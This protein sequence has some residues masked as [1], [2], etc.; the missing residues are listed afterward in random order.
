MDFFERQDVARR[1][2]ALL[3]FYFLMA[4]ILIIA[5]VYAVFAFTFLVLADDEEPGRTQSSEIAVQ[6]FWDP[7]LFTGV[8][9]GTIVLVSGGSLYRI[10][11]LSGG[12]HTVAE[13]LGGRLLHPDTSDPDERKLLNVV[14][15]MAIASGVPVPPVY[16]MEKESGINAFAAGFQPG[17]AVIGVTR[18]CI[19][20]LNRDELQGV[21]A[22][23][24][25]HILNGDMRLNVRLMGVLFGILLISIVG[26]IIFRST[27]VSS[28]RSYSNDN[29]KGG[30]PLP[31]LGLALYA[32]GYIGVIFGRLIK[33]AI[34]RQRE[35]LADASAVQFT[36]NPDGIANALKKIGALSEGSKLQ[37]PEA[38]EASHMFFGDAI[39]A[40][41]LGLMAT[42]P[43][44]TARIRQ[45][46]PTFDGDFSKVRREL[47]KP[48]SERHRETLKRAT[49]SERP[50]AGSKRLAFDP[51]KAI[52]EIGTL[53]PQRLAYAAALLDAMPEPVTRMAHEPHGARAL[54]Y[55]LLLDNDEEVRKVQLGQLAEG[56]DPQVDFET[57]KILPQVRQLDP[58]ARLPMV[59]LAL[60]A[61]HQLSP[62]QYQAFRDNIRKLIEADR[63][64]SL[65]EFA[66]RQMLMRHL[67]PQ[68]GELPKRANRHRTIPPLVEP[69]AKVLS[70]LARVGQRDP[71][72]IEQAFRAGVDRLNWS[73]QR[74][75]LCPPDRCGLKDVDSAL[76]ELAGAS[77]QLKR[78]VLE[79]CAVTISE[80]G[81]VTLEEGELLRAIADSLDAPMPPILEAP[82]S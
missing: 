37:E 14:E 11:S 33:A 66:L 2:T 1:K 64:I 56:A 8:A 60:P 23:E 47:A 16:V 36:R 24:F 62:N 48:Q 77:P 5:S 51:A 54:V 55:A 59:E 21:M 63:R 13:M 45:I 6:S 26:W 40:S 80:D 74:L 4:V 58:R 50:V 19:Q 67:G 52:A 78:A 81:E 72:A 65:F 34:S 7:V 57:R 82:V 10:A 25:S 61:L 76:Q 31:L 9:V 29:K 41:F 73:G 3:V 35:Y 44:L 46:D 69:T 18:G 42:H 12:G 17:D 53:D 22:H 32:I 75:E 79:A 20:N 49:A 68:F 30:N 28:R 71:N 15:E 39:G 27:I 43:P 70:A 38:E